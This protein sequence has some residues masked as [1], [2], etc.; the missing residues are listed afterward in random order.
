MVVPDL[1]R[2]PIHL[3]LLVHMSGGRGE[4]GGLLYPINAET[5]LEVLSKIAD[6]EL[7]MKGITVAAA[8]GGVERE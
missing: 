2:F 4:G 8:A 3:R 1:T 6:H 7:T 5:F